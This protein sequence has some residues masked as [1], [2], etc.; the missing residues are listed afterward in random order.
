MTSRR[1]QAKT[2]FLDTKASLLWLS[3]GSWPNF[4]YPASH[5]AFITMPLP[6]VKYIQGTWN[7]VPYTMSYFPVVFLACRFNKTETWIPND[8]LNLIYNHSCF[9]KMAT[10]Y[11]HTAFILSFLWHFTYHIC[12][13]LYALLQ[14]KFCKKI[15][16]TLSYRYLNTSLLVI[17]V[18]N[19][20]NFYNDQRLQLVT[21][22]KEQCEIWVK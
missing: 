18:L 21:A 22:P 5:T 10:V 7:S 19:I 20:T 17:S 1:L 15:N 6:N 14:K 2:V 12:S 16:A 3:K 13:F 4:H 9:L 8:D 11:L